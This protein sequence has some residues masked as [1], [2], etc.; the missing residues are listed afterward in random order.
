MP[1]LDAFDVEGT[2]GTGAGSAAPPDATAAATAGTG[3]GQA[4]AGQADGGQPAGGAGAAGAPAAPAPAKTFT[5]ADLDR[6]VQDRLRRAEAQY[7]ARLSQETARLQREYEA[8][9]SQGGERE[10]PDPYEARFK[11]IEEQVEDM[12]LERDL[13]GLFAKHPDAKALE[14]EIIRTAVDLG[15][16]NLEL[17]WRHMKFEELSKVDP[18]AIEKTAYERG[19]R[20]GVEEYVKTKREQAGATP[21]PEGKGG[22]PPPKDAEKKHF[23]SDRERWEHAEKAAIENIRARRTATQ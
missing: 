14:Q 22:A 12:A 20:E 4:P 7:Q 23:G 16:T 15:T 3:E 13:Q 8:R 19:K 5:Q 18:K 21:A 17:A 10:S 9:M 1:P 2:G 11:T 6:T